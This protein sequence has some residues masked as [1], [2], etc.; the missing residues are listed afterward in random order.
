VS[1]RVCDQREREY[2]RAM[3]EKGNDEREMMEWGVKEVQR[4]GT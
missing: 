4:D 1:K 3:E 2:E